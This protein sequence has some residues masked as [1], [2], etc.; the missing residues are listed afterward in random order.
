VPESGG[1]PL[2]CDMSSDIASRPLD[3]SR[4]AL[5]YA[6]AQKNLGPAGVTVVILRRDLLARCSERIPKI[7][8]YHR[9]ADKN[10][11]LNTPPVFAI[12]VLGLVVRHWLERG[13]LPEVAKMNEE[14][15]SR[16]YRA[17][18]ESGGFYRGVAEPGSR[19]RM[20]VTFRLPDETLEGRFA[21]ETSE[22]GLIGLQ[23]HRSTGG[24]RASI[25]NAVP[26]ESVRVLIDFMGEF[27]KRHG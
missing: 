14:K 11:L 23:G 21:K 22:A 10:S 4:H 20:N 5:I 12:Y 9:V 19:S 18:D 6:G 8:S 26:L 7:F 27:Q 17:I 3:V 1:V 2:F 24:I 13:G 25:Y 16:L 15:A